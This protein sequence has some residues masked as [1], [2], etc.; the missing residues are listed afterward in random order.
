VA[1]K[2]IGSTSASEAGILAANTIFDVTVSAAGS[3]T[4]QQFAEID[5]AVPGDSSNYADQEATLA[6]TLIT[7]T[8][9]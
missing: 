3:R 2:V 7:L 9:T 1:G 4:L 8:N 5:H 6:D